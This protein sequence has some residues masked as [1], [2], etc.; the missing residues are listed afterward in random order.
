ME[1]ITKDML[2]RAALVYLKRASVERDE[3]VLIITEPP[4]DSTVVEAL[5]SAAQQ[6][7]A[8]PTVAMIPYRGEQ[9]IEPPKP[10]AAAM[11]AA[12]VAV[13]LIPYESADFYTRTSLEMLEGGTR[14]L[15]C[16]SATA[17]MFRDLIYYHDFTVTDRINDVLKETISAAKRVKITSSAGTDIEAELGDR[18]VQVNPAF[19]SERGEEG[20]IPPGVV[21][22]APIEESWNGQAVFDA[23]AYPVGLLRHPITVNIRQGRITQISGSKEADQFRG[24]FES[25]NDPNV[26]IVAHYGFGTNPSISRLT[27]LK[28]LNERKCGIFD[29]GFGTNDLPCFK[30]KVRAKGHTDGLMSGAT[31]TFDERLVLKEGQFVHPELASLLV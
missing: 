2:L 9:N 25:K 14:V 12:D 28:F 15:G 24:W 18:P 4:S 16:M 26:Y 7:G 17:E 20:Y 11:K 29:I 22:Q 30:G 23:F 21:G 5:F 31:V 8:R 13:S 10:L 27:G 1:Q 19:V 6:K 3:N